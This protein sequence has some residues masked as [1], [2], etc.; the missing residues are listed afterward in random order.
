MADEATLRHHYELK[1]I[2]IGRAVNLPLRVQVSHV[3][4]F[5][6]DFSLIFRPQVLCFSSASIYT[7]L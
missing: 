7:I 6:A 1:L 2:E 5:E 3:Y 4:P